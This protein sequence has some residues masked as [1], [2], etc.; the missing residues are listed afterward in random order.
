MNEIEGIDVQ[1]RQPGH[2]LRIF[3]YHLVEIEGA[4]AEN[5]RKFGRNLHGSARFFVFHQLVLAAVYGVQKAFCKVRPRAEKLHVLAHAHAGDAARDA[6]IVPHFGTHQIVALI[7]NGGRLDGDLRAER[8]EVL[9]Q[10]LGPEHREIG[11]GRGAQRIQRVEDPERSFRDERVQDAEAVPG[12]E[13]PAV[14]PH[15]ADRFGHPCGIAAEQLVIFLDAHELDDAQL[16]DEMV[17]ELLRLLFG[18]RS[19]VQIA[20]DI[21]V[22]EG[23]IPADG[24]RRAVLILHRRQIAEIDRL[25]GFLCVCRGTGNVAAVDCRHRFQVF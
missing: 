17:D 22:Q 25:N 4:V 15:A 24:H 8:L 3:S 10:T 2:H 1:P 5:G 11:F 16:H 21:N 23:G 9:G 14:H 20:L 18:E 12:D 13:R 19:L 7:L 6:V